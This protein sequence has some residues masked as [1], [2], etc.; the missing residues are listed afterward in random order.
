MAAD[1]LGSYQKLVPLCV[2]FYRQE[3]AADD[4]LV[5]EADDQL[6]DLLGTLAKLLSP[7]F[8]GAS[9][10]ASEPGYVQIQIGQHLLLVPFHLLDDLSTD[11]RELEEL[12]DLATTLK[13]GLDST[14]CL[15]G[16]GMF[17][18]TLRYIA[19]LDYCEYAIEG[20]PSA[21]NRFLE[22]FGWQPSPSRC[23]LSVKSGSGDEGWT[24]EWLAPFSGQGSSAPVI[25]AVRSMDHGKFDVVTAT[26]LAGVVE[27]TNLMLVLPD[28][29]RQDR[30]ARSFA[31][32]EAPIGW[33]PL[34]LAIALELGRYAYWLAEEMMKYRKTKPVKALKRALALTS[35]T[36]LDH[37]V[38]QIRRCLQNHNAPR[39]S[40]LQARLDLRAR[41]PKDST[42]NGIRAELDTTIAALHAEFGGS[43]TPE[44]A[45]TLSKAFLSDADDAMRHLKGDLDTLWRSN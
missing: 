10:F 29:I 12:C 7:S 45:A 22:L 37:H 31:F 3:A 16:S 21:R 9:P 36:F 23:C 11:P 6:S 18:G 35:L 33:V 42:W 17:L 15:S 34:R 38:G 32:Q 30:T 44:A 20:D 43:Q 19:D 26:K 5:K 28:R 14:I 8:H 25:S 24:G 4:P 27:A 40:A 1:E 41:L 39:R 2:L 13:R